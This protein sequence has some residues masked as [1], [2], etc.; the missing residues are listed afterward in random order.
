MPNEPSL[1][2]FLY[3]AV[4][5][6]LSQITSGSRGS[7]IKF[8]TKGNIADYKIAVPPNVKENQT[9][10]RLN[11]LLKSIDSNKRE[12]EALANLRDTLLPKLMSGQI[13]VSKVDIMQLNNHLAANLV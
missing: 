11:L 10:Q 6:N 2:G 8:I 4:K 13:D 12:I 1:L 3:C 5:R 9:V 7:V